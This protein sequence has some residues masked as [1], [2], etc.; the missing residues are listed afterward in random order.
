MSEDECKSAE[1]WFSLWESKFHDRSE[2][3]SKQFALFFAYCRETV[4]HIVRKHAVHDYPTGP[5]TKMAVH[6]T[7]IRYHVIES[8][9]WIEV[10]F[11][12]LFPDMVNGSMFDTS[13]PI[14]KQ[15]EQRNLFGSKKFLA[16]S[17]GLSTIRQDA[18][19]NIFNVLDTIDKKFQLGL[20][21]LTF[22]RELNWAPENT[23]QFKDLC[24]IC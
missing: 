2:A 14:S 22:A 16:F 20:F 24:I 3:D 9:T 21:L 10:Q 12:A 18:H 13:D 4:S 17:Y 5:Y 11:H 1:D 19:K 15:N 7:S 6:T 8:K 23:V